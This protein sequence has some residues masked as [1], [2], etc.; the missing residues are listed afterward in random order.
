MQDMNGDV[1]LGCLINGRM[2]YHKPTA[3]HVYDYNGLMLSYTDHDISYCVTPNH[4]MYTVHMQDTKAGTKYAKDYKISD[5]TFVQAK[6]I[7]QGRWCMFTGT[8][9]TTEGN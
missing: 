4:R 5:A 9:N 8:G 7:V 6:D 1:E 2:E 3:I